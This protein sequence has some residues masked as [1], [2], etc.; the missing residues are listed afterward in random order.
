MFLSFSVMGTTDC[1][2]DFITIP[3]GKFENQATKEVQSGERFCGTRLPEVKSKP[4]L[5]ENVK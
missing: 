1:K 5:I 2:T 4:C 3:G